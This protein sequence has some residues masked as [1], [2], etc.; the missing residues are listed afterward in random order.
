MAYRSLY[1]W[2]FVWKKI[3]LYT[4]EKVY[5]RLDNEGDPSQRGQERTGIG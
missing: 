3:D 2:Y 4:P 1:F 5:V